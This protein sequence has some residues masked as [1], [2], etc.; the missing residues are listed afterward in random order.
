MVAQSS[1]KRF[2]ITIFLLLVAANF[3]ILAFPY[4]LGWYMVP[5]GWDTP[6]YIHNMRLIEEQ[7]FQAFFEKSQGI[8]FYS[9]FGYFI[10]LVF[11]ISY[12]D[13]EKILPII[14]A[15]LFSAVNCQ[16]TKKLTN[17]WKLSLLA[18]FLT[19]IGWNILRLATDLHRNLFSFLLV[20]TA[21]FLLLPEILEQ[22]CKKKM[23]IFVAL[24]VAAG[25]AHLETFALAMLTLL[26]LFM[27][28]LNKGLHQKAKVSIFCL[29][30]PSLF[31]IGLESP[32][33]TKYLEGHPLSSMLQYSSI[34]R[35]A[36]P[37][38]YFT[39]WGAA[40]TPF[41]L[42]GLKNSIS[43]YIRKPEKPFLAI[44]LWNLILI[45][46][47]FLPFLIPQ[48]PGVRF[49]Y[50]VT[51]PLLAT[52]ELSRVCK[53]K[54]L[55]FKTTVFVIIIISLVLLRVVYLS[56]NYKPWISE[57]N[58]KRL[59]WINSDKQDKPCII[60]FY[61]D[62]GEWTM[63]YAELNRH[64]VWALSGTK[65]N[66]YFGY[67]ENLLKSEPTNSD[68]EYINRTSYYFWSE[69]DNL[70]LSEAR[71]YIIAEWY[72][73]EIN[74]SDFTQPYEGVFRKMLPSK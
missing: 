27:F 40:L 23:V 67:V 8:N 69:I 55:K 46:G 25:L 18:M 33:I 41:Y 57:D 14:L 22:N 72:D 38:D 66:V 13:S 48:M 31:V 47:S 49:L 20:E 45:A 71:I 35:F 73:P 65:I 62:K 58:Y 56:M 39:S 2:F 9:I 37:W 3:L 54:S 10:S 52:I 16:I 15:V 42:L 26:I 29:L 44:P 74:Q 63:G 24:L 4:L 32:Y 43:F 70:T 12:L 30:V 11:H 6:W 17:S 50:L 53:R 19:C 28:Y 1:Q 34:P 68:I 60:V 61:F 51:V 59:L 21:L 5:V 36:Y 64:W 7:G